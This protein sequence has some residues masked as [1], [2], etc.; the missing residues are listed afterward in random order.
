MANTWELVGLQ[1]PP[2]GSYSK[3]T[4]SEVSLALGSSWERPICIRK[5]TI[6]FVP[7]FASVLGS[8]RWAGGGVCGPAPNVGFTPGSKPKGFIR[9]GPVRGL[10]VWFFRGLRRV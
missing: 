6:K 7:E 8:T 2:V 4:I 9:M 1:C 3:V 5:V 10:S